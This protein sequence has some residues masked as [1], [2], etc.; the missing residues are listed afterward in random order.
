M[1]PNGQ[2]KF[3]NSLQ[4]WRLLRLGMDKIS[5]KKVYF[6]SLYYNLVVTNQLSDISNVLPDLSKDK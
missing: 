2:S 4:T 1:G 3:S 6:L 5:V